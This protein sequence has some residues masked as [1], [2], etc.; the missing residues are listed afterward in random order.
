MLRLRGKTIYQIEK[1]TGIFHYSIY[2]AIDLKHRKTSPHLSFFH[3]LAEGLGCTAGW[4]LQD[5]EWKS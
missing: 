2:R 1:E 5:E 3:S 4:L